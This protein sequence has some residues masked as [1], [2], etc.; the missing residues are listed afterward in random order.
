MI[1]RLT[2][3]LA[4]KKQTSV[5]IDVQGVGYECQVP[6]SD[7][8]MLGDIG[9]PLILWTHLQIRE[10]AHELYG[11]LTQASRQ[12][13]RLLIKI[14]GVGPKMA[15]TI[16]SGV[17]LSRF[18]D[19]VE[20]QEVDALSRLP[21]IGKK[22]AERLM[23]ELRD[24]FKKNPAEWQSILGAGLGGNGGSGVGAASGSILRE[25]QTSVN[26][27]SSIFDEAASALVN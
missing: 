15:L 2:G 6:F 27:P 12:F 9:A 4:A 25:P 13:F 8:L 23:L 17:D 18:V 11:F 26:N 19:A 14:S 1:S 24:K 7:S 21:G 20:R 5:L 10:D 16:L 3:T 22:T